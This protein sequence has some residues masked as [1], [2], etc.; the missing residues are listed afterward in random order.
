MNQMTDEKIKIG[1]IIGTFGIKG[2]LKV[3]SESDFVEYRFRKN[4]N[5]TL[6][7]S[8]NSLECTIFSFRYH[9]KNLLIKINDL[10]DI[11]LVEKYVGYDIYADASDE[12]NLDENE[13]YIDDLVGINVYDEANNY[14]GK[15]EDFIEVPQGYIM[16]IRNN[17]QKML[18]PFVDEYVLEIDEEKMIIKVLEIC[19]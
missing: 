16:E 19:Q 18:I 10:N 3:Y 1:K 8:K 14:I 2:E 11:N 17:S 4:A 9:N 13:Y 12:P 5:I 15:V 7:S 6:I